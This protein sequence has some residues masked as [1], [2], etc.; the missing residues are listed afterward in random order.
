MDLA[1]KE[2]GGRMPEAEAKV[3]VRKIVKILCGLLGP[4]CLYMRD[5]KEENVVVDLET[6]DM[7]LIDFGCGC[8][9]LR[10]TEHENFKG[11]SAFVP[12]EY[13]TTGKYRSE[14]Q[15]SWSI[16]DLTFSLVFG[17]LRFR[18]ESQL[19]HF[20]ESGAAKYSITPCEEVSEMG[21]Q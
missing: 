4:V 21:R 15:T 20:A 12:P 17:R 3:A 7:Y 18:N 10:T 1:Q 6:K 8:Y 5:L 11:T 19:L 16:G 14:Q 13:H 2:Y 9:S